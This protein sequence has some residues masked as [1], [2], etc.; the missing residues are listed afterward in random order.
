M[1]TFKLVLFALAILTLP[2][3]Y[4]QCSQTTIIQAPEQG[5]STS[6]GN[7]RMVEL[8][9]ASFDANASGLSEIAICIEELHFWNS[10][11]G[12]QNY[13]SNMR[14]GEYYLKPGGT[15]LGTIFVRPGNYDTIIFDLDA[16]CYAGARSAKVTNTHGSFSSVLGIQ[17]RFFGQL[18]V[19]EYG[20][21][22][23]LFDMERMLEGL[24]EVRADADVPGRFG[25]PS[26]TFQQL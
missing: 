16:E 22:K 23:I 1:K 21:E 13:D 10:Q 2:L 5:E 11:D 4:N 26:G 14:L 18:T 12:T 25:G 24:D 15:S 8:Q 17:M 3:T 6:T 9:I 19:V 7:P 20:G